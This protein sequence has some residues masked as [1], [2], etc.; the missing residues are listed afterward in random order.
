MFQKKLE[1][2]VAGGGKKEPI[3]SIKNGKQRSSLK[4]GKKREQ[5]IP[6]SS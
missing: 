5:T 4:M 6:V 2:V 1:S 3:L